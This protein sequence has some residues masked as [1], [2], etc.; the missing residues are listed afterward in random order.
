MMI[1]LLLLTGLVLAM[2]EFSS[3]NILQST[4]LSRESR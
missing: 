1:L 4:Q 3:F 2:F